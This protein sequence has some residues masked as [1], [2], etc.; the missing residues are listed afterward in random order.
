MIAFCIIFCALQ[1]ALVVFLLLREGRERR[2]MLDRLAAKDL[3][4]FRGVPAPCAP[5]GRLKRL[6]ENWNAEKA[7]KEIEESEHR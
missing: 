5:K 4:E 2:E 1:S 6:L 3:K 7:A